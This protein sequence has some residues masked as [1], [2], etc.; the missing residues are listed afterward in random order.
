MATAAGIDRSLEMLVEGAPSFGIP[1]PWTREV[2]EEARST[3][4]AWAPLRA[5]ATASPYEYLRQTRQFMQP[6]SRLGDPLSLRYFDR[7]SLDLVAQA[8]K[9]LALLD[10]ECRKT[11]YPLCAMASS[12]GYSEMLIERA[13]KEAVLAFAGLDVEENRER[14]KETVA[15]FQQQRAANESS[16]F[17]EAAT[18]PEEGKAGEVA[19]QLV[20]DIRSDWDG[21]RA[22]F[23]V[24]LEG[25]TP[26]FDLYL[27]LKRQRRV[28]ENIERFSVV[29]RRFADR[30][31]GI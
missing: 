29:M 18:S 20:T 27:V 17:F 31:Y 28:T 9:L 22:E 8:E 16:E 19:L 26:D 2:R 21:M 11:D 15:A 23:G 30:H 12:S 13:T 14:L 6:E 4:E 24:L 1:A 7:L 3:R 25:K 10:R 5:I